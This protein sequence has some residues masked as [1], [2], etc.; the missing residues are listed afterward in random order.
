MEELLLFRVKDFFL[1]DR[2]GSGQLRL[3]PKKLVREAVEPI[4]VVAAEGDH[5]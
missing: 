2:T 4:V 5:G 1:S 3:V